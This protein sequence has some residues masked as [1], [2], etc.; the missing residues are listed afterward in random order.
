MVHPWGKNSVPVYVAAQPEAAAK[1]TPEPTPP[2][3]LPSFQWSQIEASDYFT[4]ISNLRS[5]ACPEQTIR[6][7][8][9]A[10]VAS[11]Y[12][13]KRQDIEKQGMAAD[14]DAN[15][16]TLKLRQ[17][18]EEEVQLLAQLLGS[19]PQN[20]ANL[21][22][23]NEQN[24]SAIC[25]THPSEESAQISPVSVPLVFVPAGP[26]VELNEQQVAE[27]KLLTQN[28]IKAIGGENQDPKDPEYLRRWQ[29]AQ[30]EF[31]ELLR[32]KF[33]DEFFNRQQVQAAN[34]K[35]L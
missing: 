8:I 18:H 11:I 9:S 13:Q 35:A 27:I 15:T 30:P 2:G 22:A 34:L 6:D 24:V 32:I 29:E 10:D 5:I 16:F 17:L 33:G 4:Y 28:F 12:R 26:D 1:V 14:W 25:E 3:Q 21:Q 20:E 7:I 23:Q 19:A 31:D